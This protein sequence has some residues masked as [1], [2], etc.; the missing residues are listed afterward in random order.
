MKVKLTE[1][2][3]DS[4]LA[5]KKRGEKAGGVNA[6]YR[7]IEVT[8]FALRVGA[9]GARFWII[10]YTLGKRQRTYVIGKRELYTVVAARTKAKELLGG[11]AKGIDPAESKREA[12]AAQTEREGA[13]TFRELYDKWLAEVGIYKKSAAND[14][15]SRKKFTALE[16]VKASD[17]TTA[18]IETILAGL[19]GTPIAANRALALI[20]TVCRWGVRR[21]HLE[22]DPAKGIERPYAEAY[23]IVAPPTPD[24]LE[25]FYAVLNA[26][27]DQA[28][29][30]AIRLVLWTGSRLREILWAK[31]D[32]FDLVNATL[33]KRITKSGPVIVP[34]NRLAHGLLCE[35][36]RT[37]TSEWVFP[38]RTKPT[39]PRWDADNVWHPVRKAIGRDTMTV[40]DHRHWFATV[41]LNKGGIPKHLIAPLLGHRSSAVTDRYAHLQVSALQ[42]ETERA[43]LALAPPA[44]KR[45]A[46]PASKRGRHRSAR[47]K[48]AAR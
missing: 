22:S 26:H 35:M 27:P 29:A 40:H 28:V 37:A 19:R 25:A 45:I 32:K 7:D 13:P 6:Y 10:E 33:L 14:R 17:I 34:L 44:P 36:K 20:K 11:V 23:R 24:E 43:M 47:R 41:L 38:S 39:V 30:N 46:P 4:L 15:S 3:A 31:W 5:P 9:G 48:A 2:N 12:V 1:R 16:N 8:G 42:V 21:G 18:R